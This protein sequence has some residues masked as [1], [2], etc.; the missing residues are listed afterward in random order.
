MGKYDYKVNLVKGNKTDEELATKILTT[1]YRIYAEQQG[2]EL[3]DIKI[4]K[5]D[6]EP[7]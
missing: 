1:L 5:K 7:A 2:Y 6:K 3:T 4:T